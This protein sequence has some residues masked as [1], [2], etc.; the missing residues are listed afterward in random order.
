MDKMK[1]F[2]GQMSKDGQFAIFVDEQFTVLDKNELVLNE[3]NI[4]RFHEMIKSSNIKFE[5]INK[6]TRTKENDNMK[7]IKNK[8]IEYTHL[9]KPQI[10][11]FFEVL[12][13]G[14]ENLKIYSLMDIYE[15]SDKFKYDDEKIRLYEEI[16][17]SF[18]HALILHTLIGIVK[19]ALFEIKDDNIVKEAKEFIVL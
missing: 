19:E 18:Y 4:N 13:K 2:Y 12:A 6:I 3:K 8:L 5:N 15:Q 10:D 9:S 16:T 7:L 14:M 17:G 1:M 11:L